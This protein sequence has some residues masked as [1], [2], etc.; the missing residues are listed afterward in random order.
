MPE[1]VVYVAY[2]ITLD[3]EDDVTEDTLIDH[4]DLTVPPTAEVFDWGYREN[5][6]R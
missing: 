6:G 1:R 2:Q 5:Y 4:P 3:L